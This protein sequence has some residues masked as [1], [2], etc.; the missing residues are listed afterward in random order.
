[1]KRLK[2]IHKLPLIAFSHLV[3]EKHS[4]HHKS[5]TGILFMIT[6]VSISLIL[7]E[8]FGKTVKFFADGF[9]YS[10]HGIGL[11]PMVEYIVLLVKKD[12]N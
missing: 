3:G 4:Q 2:L 12:E 11:T 10:L 1:M 7:G 6:G 5:L 8:H 9:G